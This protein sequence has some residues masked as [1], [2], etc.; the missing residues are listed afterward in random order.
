MYVMFYIYDDGD[1]SFSYPISPFGRGLFESGNVPR[2][3]PGDFLIYVA[4]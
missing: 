1:M 4:G 2:R 3:D